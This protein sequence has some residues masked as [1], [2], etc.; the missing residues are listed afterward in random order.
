MDFANPELAYLRGQK[1]AHEKIGLFFVN[2]EVQ[3]VQK[4][5]ETALKL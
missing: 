2:R 3:E 1:R 5:T 4:N